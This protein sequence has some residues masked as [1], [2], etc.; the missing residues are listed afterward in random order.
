[1]DGGDCAAQGD[2]GA[3]P[4]LLAE[5]LLES[6]FYRNNI[7]FSL[8][9]LEQHVRDEYERITPEHW[10][11]VMKKV[12]EGP[13]KVYIDDMDE[14]PNPDEH[15]GGESSSDSEDDNMDCEQ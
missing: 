15:D 6:C 7:T 3:G 2:D 12:K 9:D 1:M 11:A 4:S 5:D 10:Q 13:E 8:K 14:E